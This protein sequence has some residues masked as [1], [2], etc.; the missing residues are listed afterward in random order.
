MTELFIAAGGGGDP[1]GTALVHTST[2]AGADAVVLTYGWERPSVDPVPGPFAA[3][4]FTGLDHDALPVAL[5]TTGTRP[6]APRVSTLPRLAG[7]L[8]TRLALLD[9]HEGV[10]GLA[11]Q[12]GRTARALGA[13]R[14]SVVDV[15]GD[16]L[17][18][19][20][21]PTLASPLLDALALAAC[22]LAGVR[23]TVHVTG[24]GLDGE[25]P[26]ETLLARLPGA[27][28]GLGPTLPPWAAD[29]LR[30]HPSEASALLAAAAAG[31]RGPC[32][33]RSGA[34]PLTDRSGR[35]W[36]LPLSRALEHNPLARGLLSARPATL[37][38]AEE[39]SLKLYGFNEV[40]RERRQAVRRHVTRDRID[41]GTFLGEL[42]A[43]L[44]VQRAGH[45]G[46]RYVSVRCAIESLGYDWRVTEHVRDLL[47]RHRPGVDA[48]P[49]LSLVD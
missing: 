8:P 11:D 25:V 27:G 12:I 15:G 39:V 7:H 44:Q 34:L 14:V 29:V 36:S 41:R 2:G 17:A 38:G 23:T 1:V 45:P 13:D 19:G 31:L 30:W 28:S 3:H 4:D 9:P 5:V 21:E 22:R 37:A 42:D 48:F 33:T 24:P 43:W 46:A 6:V 47:A 10:E 16:V 26:E 32:L 20:D 35:V 40:A 49:L 18:H